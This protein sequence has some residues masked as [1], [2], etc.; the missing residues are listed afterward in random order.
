LNQKSN[1]KAKNQ[2]SQ[3]VIG[4]IENN[5]LTIVRFEKEDLIDYCET[6][7]KYFLDLV[8]RLISMKS[9]LGEA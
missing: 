9:I 4:E 6:K 2:D 5:I 1:K 7:I 8:Q 3:E